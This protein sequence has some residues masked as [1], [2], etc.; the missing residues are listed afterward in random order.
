MMWSVPSAAGFITLCPPAALLGIWEKIVPECFTQPELH[1][2]LKAPVR[3]DTLT[4]ALQWEV[5]G[6]VPHQCTLTCW[7]WQIA[8]RQKKPP[9]PHTHPD[10]SDGEQK[11]PDLDG[12]TAHLYAAWSRNRCGISLPVSARCSCLPSPLCCAARSSSAEKHAVSIAV[13]ERFSRTR[14]RARS[15][16]DRLR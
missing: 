1:L 7:A 6:K 8:S 15:A 4:P 3:S 2:S 14:A 5:L 9:N 11:R 16:A 10:G 12:Y 13:R